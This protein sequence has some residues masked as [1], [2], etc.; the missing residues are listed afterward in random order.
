MKSVMNS[1]IIAVVCFF[2]VAQAQ[3]QVDL[4]RQTRNP[5]FSALPHTRPIQVGITLPVTCGVGELFYNSTQSASNP[6]YTCISANTWSPLGA[7]P[8]GA[9]TVAN[10]SLS[11]PGDIISGTGA[12]AGSLSLYEKAINGSNAVS[13]AAPDS[14]SAAYTLKLPAGSPS[15]GQSLI[16]AAPDSTGVAQAAWGAQGSG[17]GG[18]VSEITLLETSG[19]TTV[20]LAAPASIPA[21]YTLQLPGAQPQAGQT[22]TFGEPDT[23]R[24]SQ[25]AWVT[26]SGSALGGSASLN[27]GSYANLPASCTEG[28]MY[29]FTDSLYNFARCTAA[30][31][32]HF[33]N[34]K[35][36][37]PP[38]ALSLST[39][40]G[41][42][43]V[44]LNTTHGYEQMNAAP[45]SSM[46]LRSW[47]APDTAPYT[48][49]IV[50]STPALLDQTNYRFWNVGFGDASGK[51]QVLQCGVG[52]G[53]QSNFYCRV[54]RLNSSGNYAGEDTQPIVIPYNSG[55][56][57]VAI[58]ND[59]TLLHFGISTDGVSF[60]EFGSAS[61]ASYLSS[62]SSLVYGFLNVA[63]TQNLSLNFLGVY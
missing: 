36:I 18:P 31:W 56:V 6:I 48:K 62:P 32:H 25:G 22:L 5:D 39:M 58:G 21:S 10:N 11:C 63:P 43:S 17:Q 57:I 47:A 46:A 41:A 19:S 26:P 20:S 35:L 42:S 4:G 50:L 38:S 23:N 52:A 27:E 34:G 44:T 45:G 28:S 1:R 29:L 33:L 15:A 30:T 40:V 16:F 37:T 14:I 13:I 51:S 2:G 55:I 60:F 7:S 8:L 53:T 12:T 3:S 61:V 9:C 24:V 59:G 49:Y 54:T